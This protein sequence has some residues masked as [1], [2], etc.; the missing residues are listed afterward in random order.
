M[1]VNKSLNYILAKVS[2][3][4]SEPKVIILELLCPLV[5]YAERSSETSAAI[6]PL[7]FVATIKL[8]AP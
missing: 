3:T 7:I 8:P 2:P 6:I 4:I 1:T 5:M